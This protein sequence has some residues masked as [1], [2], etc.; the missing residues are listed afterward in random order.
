MTTIPFEKVEGLGNHFVLIDE[1]RGGPRDWPSL[2]RTVCAYGSGIGGDGLLVVGA[3]GAGSLRSMR[4]FNPDGSEDMCGNGLRCVAHVAV[5][6]HAGGEDRPWTI[7]TI[8]GP[9]EV[10]VTGAANATATVRASLGVPLLAPAAM[11][12]C[13]EGERALD[14]ELVV[15]DER[16]TASLVSMG[17]P[18]CVI[19]GPPPDE[20]RFR[21]LSPML[22]EDTRFP[23]GISVMWATVVGAHELRLRVWERAVG[24]TRACGTGAAAS[25]VA[26]VLTGR[27]RDPVRVRMPGGELGIEWPSQQAELYQVGPSRRVY[28]GGYFMYD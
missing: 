26:G 25:A 17:T 20:S 14:V 4:M 9:R 21:Q 3:G 5:A 22:E 8:A 6:D 27:L 10:Q 2:A 23:E 28:C 13:L 18:H 1:A 11:P 24:E 15:G 16:I 7:G 19:F 12:A